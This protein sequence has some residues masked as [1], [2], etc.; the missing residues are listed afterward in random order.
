MPVSTSSMLFVGITLV[1]SLYFVASQCFFAI[2]NKKVIKTIKEKG[3]FVTKR[4]NLKFSDKSSWAGAFVVFFRI[5]AILFVFLLGALIVS[6]V[7]NYLNWGKIILK[8]PFMV[9][10]AVG[11]LNLSAEIRYQ[12]MLEKV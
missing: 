3:Q 10:C 6:F 5:I 12:T 9:F 11:F 8:M 7:Q 4:V 2:R 1:A